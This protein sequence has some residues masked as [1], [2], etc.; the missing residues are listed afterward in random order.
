MDVENFI[1]NDSIAL[2]TGSSV[3]GEGSI[4]TESSTIPW[5]SIDPNTLPAGLGDGDDNTQLSESE[6]EDFVNNDGID[7]HEDTTLAGQI[8]VTTPLDCADGQILSFDGLT[9]SWY[10]I[11]FST[12]IDQDSDGNH[13]AVVDHFQ[14]GAGTSIPVY[15]PGGGVLPGLTTTASRSDIFAYRTFDGEN[16]ATAGLYAVVVGQNFA[17]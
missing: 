9:T 5:T 12:V 17:N 16:I 13:S 11:D 1:V 8:L 15:W 6:V 14:T 2:A 4:L 3:T 10:C 7:L